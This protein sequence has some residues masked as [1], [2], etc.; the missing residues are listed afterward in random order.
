MFINHSLGQC[1]RIS[2][3]PQWLRNSSTRL[4]TLIW[5]WCHLCHPNA[6]QWY[7]S[8]CRFIIEINNPSQFITLYVK[9]NLYL[10]NLFGHNLN[11]NV[12]KSVYLKVSITIIIIFNTCPP[13]A[14]ISGM[15]RWQGGW[16][17]PGKWSKTPAT[18][19]LEF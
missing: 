8:H 12:L 15:Q 13:C 18:K 10:Q 16:R 17:R 9:E 5:K 2:L 11:A 7:W 4:N 1:K 6:I 3:F 19:E 14:C